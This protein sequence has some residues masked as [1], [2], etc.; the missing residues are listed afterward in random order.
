MV[1]ESLIARQGR[2]EQSKASC[3]QQP[4]SSTTSSPIAMLLKA[5]KFFSTRLSPLPFLRINSIPSNCISSYCIRMSISS[6][7]DSYQ[8]GRFAL[9]KYQTFADSSLSYASVNLKP[10]VDSHLL[11][12][13]KRVVERVNDL[14][15][16]ELTDLWLLAQRISGMLEAKL[17]I[18]SFTFAIQDGALA[19]Q[20]VPHVHIHILPRREGDFQKNDDIYSALEEKIDVIKPRTGQEMAAEASK[21]RGWL[22]DFEQNKSKQ[23]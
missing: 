23:I 11:V 3:Q 19:G 14:S 16:A 7:P 18:K 22:Q 13:P 20:T 2:A 21:L 8:F 12:I 15:A 9:P 5:N 1:E 17:L 6:S 10:V 4:S